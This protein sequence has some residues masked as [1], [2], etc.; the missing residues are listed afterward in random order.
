[1]SLSV[2]TRCTCWKRLTQQRAAEADTQP[3]RLQQNQSER[4]NRWLSIRFSIRFS[5]R[6]SSWFSIWFF[7]RFSDWFPFRFQLMQGIVATALSEF[8]CLQSVCAKRVCKVRR[9]TERALTKAADSISRC[10]TFKR[11]QSFGIQA[12][13]RPMAQSATN[14]ALLS[15]KSQSEVTAKSQRN[16]NECIAKSFEIL[17]QKR[18]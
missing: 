16:H 9:L 18:S 6:F 5:S 14:L 4:S 3:L 12:P 11:S 8:V 7:S 17:N 15:I 13:A 2:H 10:L 1:M